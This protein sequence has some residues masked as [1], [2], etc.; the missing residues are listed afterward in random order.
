MPDSKTRTA[1]SMSWWGSSQR[2]MG[3]R[4]KPSSEGSDGRGRHGG[5]VSAESA[6][7]LAMHDILAAGSLDAHEQGARVDAHPQSPHFAHRIAIELRQLW[8]LRADDDG[9]TLPVLHYPVATASTGQYPRG[10]RRP[11]ENVPRPDGHDIQQPIIH[12][13]CGHQHQPGEKLAA[14]ANHQRADSTG[15]FNTAIHSKGDRGPRAP[16]RTKSR[17]EV[18]QRTQ[19]GLQLVG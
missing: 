9:A 12:P 18:R 15:R 2:T 13:G 3:R 4:T 11:T 7:V 19:S 16:Q 8:S 5:G 17:D 6:R 14:V 1:V 10:H